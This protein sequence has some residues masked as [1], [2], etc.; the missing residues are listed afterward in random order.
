MTKRKKSPAQLDREIASALSKRKDNKG[1][2]S[3]HAARKKPAKHKQLVVEYDVAGLSNDQIDSLTGYAVA[4]GEKSDT[5][6]VGH[7][8]VKVTSSV[9]S[10]GKGKKLVVKFDITGLSEDQIDVL[11]GEAI[12]QGEANDAGLIINGVPQ[13]VVYP[14]VP[15]TSKIV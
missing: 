7:P 2:K 10:R 14:N 3:S 1:H 8:D 9:V 5:Y 4:Q 15:V 13:N 6:D 11:Q 12:A